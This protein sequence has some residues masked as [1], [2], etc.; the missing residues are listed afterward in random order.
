MNP[1]QNHTPIAKIGPGVMKR[2]N[3]AIISISWNV[4]ELIEC[5]RDDTVIFRSRSSDE[6]KDPALFPNILQTTISTNS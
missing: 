3:T 6:V 4:S 1:F 5:V 2:E